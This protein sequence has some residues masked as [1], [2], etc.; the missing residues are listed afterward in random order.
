MTQQWTKFPQS[1]TTDLTKSYDI[2]ILERFE[3][4]KPLSPDLPNYKSI[5]NVESANGEITL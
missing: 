5:D 1:Y 2:S 4:T 3:E